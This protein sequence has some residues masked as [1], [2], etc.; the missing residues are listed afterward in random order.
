MDIVIQDEIYSLRESKTKGAALI[1]RKVPAGSVP[2]EKTVTAYMP[3]MVLKI[4][5]VDGES[6]KKDQVLMVIEAMK[7]EMEITSPGHGVVKKIHVKE[8]Q[9]VIQGAPLVTIVD[10]AQG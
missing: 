10:M 4:L 3:A 6:V 2:L 7:M 8:E 9:S 1:S 5:V